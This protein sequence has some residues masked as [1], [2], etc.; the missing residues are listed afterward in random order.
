MKTIPFSDLKSE[1]RIHKKEYQKSFEKVLDSNYFILGKEVKNFEENF[2]KYLKVKYCISVANGLEALQISL[3]SLGVGKGDEVI[4]TPISAVATTLAVLAVGATPVFVDTDENGLMDTKKIEEKIT[5][6]TK[7]LL[8]VHLY[9]NQ[10]DLETMLDLCREKKIFLIED[11]CQAHGS[12]YKGKKLGT[13]GI[14]NCFSFYPTKNLGAFGDGGA[15]VTNSKRIA[16][17]CMFT[18]DYGQVAKYEHHLY[19]LNSRLD[20]IQAAFLNIKLQYLDRY[21][22]KR[23]EIAKRYIKNFSGSIIKVITPKFV[24]GA[25]FHLF[26]V[27]VKNRS[28]LQKHLFSKGIS[29]LVHYPKT[30]PDQK[31]LSSKY[32]LL[33]LETARKLVQEI[34][35]IP[36]NPFMSFK[37][38]DYI[39]GNILEFVEK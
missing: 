29:T 34:L 26:V 6:K 3:M 36:C 20:E 7:V 19:G 4:T 27:K 14:V 22:N 10:L 12:S 32:R 37:D 11:A 39:S 15:I 38:V 33:G 13:F 28:Q 2:S 17:F 24:E 16:D 8:P 1:I 23:R 31:L 5:K 30:I 21:N 25:N 18:R 35:S 9:G